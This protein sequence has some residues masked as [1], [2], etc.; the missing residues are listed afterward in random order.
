MNKILE[1]ARFAVMAH[2]GQKRKYNNLPYVTHPARVAAR[3][4]ILPNTTEE[5]I[6]AAYLHD[7]IEDTQYTYEDLVQKFGDSIAN[8]VLDLTNVSKDRYPGQNRAFRKARDREHL[9]MI[10]PEAK[11]IKLVDRIDNL[12]EMSGADNGFLKLYLEESIELHKVLSDV[13]EELGNEL[14]NVI[15]ELQKTLDV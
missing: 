7:V 1:A 9:K 8:Y 15:E 5:M 13:D 3:V 12:R 4:S 2:A 11:R 10:S 14:K 6:C